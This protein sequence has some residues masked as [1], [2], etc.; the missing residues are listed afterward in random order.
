METYLIFAVLLWWAIEWL[1]KYMEKFN[2]TERVQDI[3]ILALALGGGIGMA[4]G[5][6]MDLFVL[7]KIQ[8]APSLFGK[9]FAG[10]GI[11][12]GSGGVFELLKAIKSIGNTSPD[13]SQAKPPD[14]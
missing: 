10:L 11:A 6:N 1:K 9:I 14:M 13:E 4:I 8:D 5:Y 7:L 12:S 2:L 3:V